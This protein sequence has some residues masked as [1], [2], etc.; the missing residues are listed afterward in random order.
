MASGRGLKKL[1]ILPFWKPGV[2][3]R[4]LGYPA[5]GAIQRENGPRGWEFTWRRTKTD[6]YSY[7]ISDTVLDVPA[8]SKHSAES[9]CLSDPRQH[10]TAEPRQFTRSGEIMNHYVQVTKQ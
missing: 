3:E 7:E 8:P 10:H 6:T 9:S 2:M 5:G 1:L 4:S